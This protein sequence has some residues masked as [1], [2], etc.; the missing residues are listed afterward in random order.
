MAAVY[1]GGVETANCHAQ[2]VALRDTHI[3]LVRSLAD[4]LPA[5]RLIVELT[6]HTRPMIGLGDTASLR[7]LLLGKRVRVQGWL[8]F[9]DEHQ[10]QSENTAPEAPDNWRATAWEIHPVT[11]IAVQ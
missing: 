4:T 6:P 11:G 8:L 9:D 2:N 10:Q 5:H 7:R 1:P 3:E